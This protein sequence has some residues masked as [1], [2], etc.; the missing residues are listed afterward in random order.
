[1]KRLEA[2]QRQKLAGLR[3]PIENRIKRLE[4]QIAKLNEKK[5]GIDA[6]LADQSIYDAA[7]KEKLKTLLSDQAFV[8]KDLAQ[9]EEDWLAQQ[10]QLETIS[11]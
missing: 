10:E 6:Q 11:S 5:A 2:E 4:E 3:K 7:N 1:Q 9:L 8:A